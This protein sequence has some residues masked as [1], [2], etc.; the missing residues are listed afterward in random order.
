MQLIFNCLLYFTSYGAFFTLVVS[1][2]SIVIWL[3]RTL[4]SWLIAEPETG[5]SRSKQFH[6]QDLAYLKRAGQ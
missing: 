6:P 2:V 5:T 3:L 4:W 1:G